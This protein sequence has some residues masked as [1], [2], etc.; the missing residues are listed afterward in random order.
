MA[1]ARPYLFASDGS[2]AAR[3]ALEHGRDTLVPGPA[4]VVCLWESV[5]TLS[6]RLLVPLTEG[7][8]ADVVGALDAKGRAAA[9]RTAEEG[10]ALLRAA[11]F[12]AEPLARPAHD[13]RGSRE[14]AD[15]WRGLLRI[16]DERDARLLVLGS[17]G[18]RATGA[19]LLGS[20]SYGVVHHSHRPVLVVPAATPSR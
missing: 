3:R 5:A 17:S 14:A 16:A 10:A 20:V 18:R 15:I 9:E 4:L 1:G 19:A 13:R 12:A 2:P 6:V 8:G 11:D 7:I